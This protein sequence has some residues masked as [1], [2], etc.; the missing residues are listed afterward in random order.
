MTQ[1]TQATSGCTARRS[2]TS[3]LHAKY[4][5]SVYDCVILRIQLDMYFVDFPRLAES[6]CYIRDATNASAEWVFAKRVKLAGKDFVTRA[7]RTL[8][9]FLHL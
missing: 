3:L 9:G 5:L 1:M 8:E 7:Y 4:T 2:I 6:L